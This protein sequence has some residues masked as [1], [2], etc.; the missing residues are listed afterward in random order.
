MM[1]TSGIV[2]VSSSASIQHPVTDQV[3]VVECL[4]GESETLAVST[5]F[6]MTGRRVS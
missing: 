1:D 2:N 6:P 3:E 5:L 4:G